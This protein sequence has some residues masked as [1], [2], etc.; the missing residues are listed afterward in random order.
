MTSSGNASPG[1]WGGVAAEIPKRLP[2]ELLAYLADG[3]AATSTSNGKLSPFSLLLM[4]IAVPSLLLR[5]KP[6]RGEMERRH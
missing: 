1:S 4:E 5:K 6:N 2:H 3:L